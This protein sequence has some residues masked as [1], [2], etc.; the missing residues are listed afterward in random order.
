M[1]NK[2]TSS[3]SLTITVLLSIIMTGTNSQLVRAIAPTK[4]PVIAQSNQDTEVYFSR[5]IQRIN[6]KNYQGAIADFT[7][8]LQQ[9]PRSAEA[10]LNRGLA[11]ARLKKYQEALQDF[12]RAVEI[13]A[14]LAP[15][16]LSRGITRTQIEDYQ[17]AF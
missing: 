13:K 1:Q 3:L 15:A 16:Y 10:H 8:V 12:D 11:L 5:G 14:D 9:N 7:Q 4:K 2:T 17:G 6:S